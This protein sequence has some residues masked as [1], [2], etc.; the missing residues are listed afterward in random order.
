MKTQR[1]R[2]KKNRKHQKHQK[3]LMCRLPT[4]R[5]VALSERL[6][7]G[8]LRWRSC[9][10][11]GSCVQTRIERLREWKKACWRCALLPLLCA[12]Q[13]SLQLQLNVFYFFSFI[14]VNKSITAINLKTRSMRIICSSWSKLRAEVDCTVTLN[15]DASIF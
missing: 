9:R 13:L 14:T 15:C 4:F 3:Q 8:L 7:R 10:L 11:R 1:L 5:S 2:K 6:A 12:Q